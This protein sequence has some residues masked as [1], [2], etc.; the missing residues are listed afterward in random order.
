MTLQEKLNDFHGSQIIGID[1]LVNVKLKGGMLNPFQG[2]IT[3]LTEGSV[4]MVFKSYK[5]FKNM[6]NKKLSGQLELSEDL[7]AQISGREYVPGP[8]QW[9]VRITDSPFITHKDKLYLECIFLR[10]GKVKYFLNGNEIDKDEI[11]GLEKEKK[12]GKQGGLRD[13]VIIRTFLMESIIKVRK[14]QQEILGPGADKL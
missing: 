9:G 6:V 11:L 12:E 7:F 8:R 14:K 13:K 4:V 2:M 3:K 1:T 5:G 10:A